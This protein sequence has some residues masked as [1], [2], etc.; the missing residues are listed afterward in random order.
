MFTKIAYNKSKIF[1]SFGQP[2]E[3]GRKTSESGDD[4]VEKKRVDFVWCG[5]DIVA[6]WWFADCHTDMDDRDCC[7][8]L[9]ARDCSICVVGTKSACLRI[10]HVVFSDGNT[11]KLHL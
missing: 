10:Y 11:H 7:C 8:R 3:K 2:C 6:Y 4:D 1:V 5:A 9:L